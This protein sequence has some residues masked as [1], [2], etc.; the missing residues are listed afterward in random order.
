MTG[1]ILAVMKTAISIPD[2][3]FRQADRLAKKLGISRSE[4]YSQAVSRFLE[5]RGREGITKALDALFTEEP[6]EL[7]TNIAAAQTSSVVD[8]GW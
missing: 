4:F 2:E 5:E 1:V 6:S 3:V 7:D 8:E